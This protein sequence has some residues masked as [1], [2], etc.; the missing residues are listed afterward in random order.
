M[1]FRHILITGGAGFAGSSLAT[2]FKEHFEGVKVT[3]LDS[4]M[5]RADRAMY[6]VKRGGRGHWRVSLR[7]RP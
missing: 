3:A 5:R 4:L 7:K 1:Q 2:L 6:E